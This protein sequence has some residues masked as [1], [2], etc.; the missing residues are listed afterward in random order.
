[1]I[2]FFSA[3]FLLFFSVV[4]FVLPSYSQ[5]DSS[6]IELLR[7]QV[8]QLMKR[9]DALEQRNQELEGKLD[10]T[11]ADVKVAQDEIFHVSHQNAIDALNA[12]NAISSKYGAELYGY[13][14]LDASYDDSRVRNG[15]YILW[16]LS[17]SQNGDDDEFTMTANQTRVG[18][19]LR[20]PEV[21]GAKTTGKIEWDFYGGG[22]ENKPR[23]RMRHAYAQLE[24]PEYE[25]SVLAGQTY[26]IISPLFPSTLNFLVGYSAG[27]LGYRRPQL[28]VSK[29]YS[30]TD[31]TDLLI[32]AALTRTIG[33]VIT[34]ID[35]GQ[36]S[37]FP[38]TQGR[39]A[40]SFPLLTEKQTTIG[41]SGHYGQEENDDLDQDF[42]T[43]SFNV[44][45]LMPLFKRVDL[46]S[47]FFTGANLDTYYAGIFQGVNTTL[48]E[49]I[50]STG[51]WAALSITPWDQWNFNV[52]AGIES[53]DD[54]Y[55]ETGGRTENKMVFGNVYYMVNPSF[56]W[57]GEVSYYVTDYKDIEDGD[58]LRFQ[59]SIIYRF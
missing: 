9:V 41:I 5:A 18:L 32:Q 11:Q 13:V 47:E 3:G 17:D 44:D 10:D 26:E 58:A 39:L 37:G 45:L 43:W 24:W 53:P 36:D 31:E 12:S 33:D 7:K 49:E 59:S 51:A 35:T 14:K 20:G 38:S 56:L 52:G 40:Y 55:V 34:D 29:N 19:N 21:G 1:M 42:D 4:L 16:S 27:N 28:R 15:N 48:A 46:K 6:E 2:R 50:P 30:L 23:F 25:L 54:F 22:D 57:G 8:E